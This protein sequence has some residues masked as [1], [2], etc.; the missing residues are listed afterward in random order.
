MT[1]EAD[2]HA[3]LRLWLVDYLITNL[4]CDPAEID[5][6]A[7]FNELGVG[8]RDAV[9]L[10]GELSEHLGQPVSP[11]DFWQNPTI[12]ALATALLTALVHSASSR[13]PREV[14]AQTAS[15]RA[16]HGQDPCRPGLIRRPQPGAAS[17]QTTQRQSQT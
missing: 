5:P 15:A 16:R 9:V 3:E 7:P 14:G 12:N 8:S 6:D 1:S 13:T 17:N 11:V 4:S 2:A 10:S